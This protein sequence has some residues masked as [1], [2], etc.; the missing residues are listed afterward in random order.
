M[1]SSF[2]LSLLSFFIFSTN[3]WSQ[4]DFLGPNF[5]EVNNISQSE[6]FSQL[7]NNI[8]D[9]QISASSFAVLDLNSNNFVLEK[10]ADNIWPIASISKLM[11][12]MVL[13]EDLN[14]DL[15]DTYKFKNE[16]RRIG[17]RDNLF[18]GDEVSNYDMLALSLIASDNTAISALISSAGV[19]EEYFVDLMNERS[20][21]LRLNNT[22]FDDPTGLSSK[23]VSTAREASFLIKEALDIEVIAELVGK[24]D[25]EFSTKQGRIRSV[26]STNE[27][28]Y[29]NGNSDIKIIG[30]K[31][32]YIESSGYCLGTKFLFNNNQE[33]I[34]VILNASTLKNRFTDTSKIFESLHNFYN[35]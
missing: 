5:G 15:D 30:G 8:S 33:F 24:K 11:S 6:Y 17:G 25:Y 7:K 12:A 19:D 2:I 21:L 13:L 32:G 18:L 23:N 28:L 1:F 22:F 4:L 35:N 34:S 10:G 27:L 26:T 29:T 20:R 16:D 14:I 3:L 9:P 31:T